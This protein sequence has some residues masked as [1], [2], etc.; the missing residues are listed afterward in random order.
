M[1]KNTEDAL[2]KI[3]DKLDDLSTVSNKIDK[4]LA[5]HK[6]QFDQHI[7]QDEKMYEEFKRMND[8][9]QQNTNSLKEHM[10]RTELL[11]ELVTKMDSRLMPIEKA[12]IELDAVKRH[13]H[14][15]LVR[16]GKIFAVI[17]GALT[18][19][20]FMKPMLIHLLIP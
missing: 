5:L 13:K 4:D 2:A 3:S 17:V 7:Q 18:L 19:L 12:K 20:A 6:S 10:H 9:L 1:P 11:E 16:W 15:Q 8:I 14:E